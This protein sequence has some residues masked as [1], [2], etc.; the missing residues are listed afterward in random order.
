MIVFRATHSRF[1][2]DLSGEGARRY[3]GR[4][5]S[6]GTPLLYTSDSRALCTLEVAV[7]LPLNIIPVDYVMLELHLPDDL[8][9]EHLSASKLLANW[10]VFP[11]PTSLRDIG[12]R[13]VSDMKVPCLKV[14]SAVVPGD[15]NY[16]LNPLHPGFNQIKVLA[17]HTFHFDRRLL[18]P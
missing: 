13:F 1:K 2:D 14:P 15:Y 6:K 3:G 5:N 9:I 16:L 4:W 7:H 11:P 12:D 8:H 18:R 10:H 17:A